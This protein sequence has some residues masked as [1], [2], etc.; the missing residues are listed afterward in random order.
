MKKLLT[1]LCVFAGLMI[2]AC[3]GANNESKPADGSKGGDSQQPANT[4][5]YQ[6]WGKLE[7]GGS[8]ASFTDAAFLLNLDVQGKTTLDK[9]NFASYDA[10]PAASNKSYI[11]SYMSGTWKAVQKEGVDALQIKLAFVEEDGSESGASTYYA[12]ESDG[13]YSVDLTVALIKGQSF[14]RTVEM[15][16]QKGQKY[17]DADAFIQAYKKEFVEPENV[18]K[19]ESTANGGV[20]YFQ[21]DGKVL[22]YVGTNNVANGTYVKTATSL[23]L[24]IDDKEIPVTLTAEKG[25]FTYTYDLAGYQTIDLVFEFPIADFAKLPVTEQGGQGG[26]TPVDENVVAELKDE[27]NSA[28]LT[29]NKDKSYKINMA[30]GGYGSFDVQKGTWAFANYV[31]TLTPESGDA[32]TSSVKDGKFIVETHIT[33]GGGQVDK[34][35]HFEADQTVIGKFM[36]A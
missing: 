23:T 33:W 2:T 13:V 34:D 8:F 3:G 4:D 31:V 15:E 10:S 28:T 19:V 5:S 12:Y 1:T 35:V 17:A 21:Q 16:G 11:A 6:F 27:A 30:F 22:I 32:Y 29:F 26:E 24:K 20:A 18:L 36:A 25:S 14:T 9:Y 7:E